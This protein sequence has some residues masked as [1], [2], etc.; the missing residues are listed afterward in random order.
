MV[1]NYPNTAFHSLFCSRH[2]KRMIIEFSFK[3]ESLVFKRKASQL[4][5]PIVQHKRENRIV[6]TWLPFTCLNNREWEDGQKDKNCRKLHGW[7][8][9]EL[10]ESVQVKKCLNERT[11]P[12][13]SFW[14]KYRAGI[15]EYKIIQLWSGEVYSSIFWM[16][17]HPDTPAQR[18]KSPGLIFLPCVT[19]FLS[20]Q[21]S[22]N[23]VSHGI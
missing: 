6:L 17:F 16:S 11:S 9:L 1:W 22:E 3:H 14:A 2:S 18:M 23:K 19:V 4:T 15:E 7:E 8:L 5:S 21:R 10:H 13:L 12:R 20:I